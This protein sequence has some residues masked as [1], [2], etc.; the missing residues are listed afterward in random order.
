MK[1]LLTAI[2]LCCVFTA[3]IAVP[4]SAAA[5]TESA[6]NINYETAQI[7]ISADTALPLTRVTLV[8][9]NPGKELSGVSAD[10]TALQH[11]R[12]L[13]TDAEGRLSYTFTANF[14]AEPTESVVLKAYAKLPANAMEKIADI[15]YASPNERVGYLNKLK[16]ST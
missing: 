15:Y 12:E 5:F 2:V 1:K 8:V 10:D 9:L 11:Q 16:G 14:A 7:S 3:M 4:A 6:Y 13:M